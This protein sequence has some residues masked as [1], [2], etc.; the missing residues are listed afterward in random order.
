VGNFAAKLCLGVEIEKEARGELNELLL[1]AK[2]GQE[3][4]D[5]S[6]PWAGSSSQISSIRG[7]QARAADC[8]QEFGLE[9][10]FAVAE[11]GLMPL[12]CYRT[13][14]NEYLTLSLE[15]TDDPGDECITAEIR[16][17][18]G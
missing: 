4:G 5:D 14:L 8:L 15:P 2:E 1:I 12:E 16:K 3:L 18:S 17:F 7:A 11:P 13:S 9:P 10:A 6:S